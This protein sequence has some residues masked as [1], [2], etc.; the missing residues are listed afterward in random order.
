VI[1]NPVVIPHFFVGIGNAGTGTPA[2]GFQASPYKWVLETG[3]GMKRE[4]QLA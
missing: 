1:L 2:T 3:F 4:L